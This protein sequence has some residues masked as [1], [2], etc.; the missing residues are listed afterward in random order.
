MLVRQGALAFELWTGKE[1]PLDVMREAT[2]AV[3]NRSEDGKP[4]KKTG[5][6]PTGKTSVALIGFM[7]AGKS[8]IG[9]ALAKKLGK[10]FVDVDKCIEKKAGKSIAHI[11]ADSGEPAF[12]ELERVITAEVARQAG[13]VIACGGG[14]VLNRSNTEALKKNAVLI[15]L[16]ASEEA[17]RKRVSPARG[18]RPLL[19]NGA[20]TESIEILMSARR[21]LYERAA[22]ITLDTSKLGIEAAACEIIERLGEYEGF[23]F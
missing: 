22:D 14:V 4:I 11:F 20:S 23:R 8:S 12:R 6:P 16:K 21:P 5:K 7:G 17:I 2:L 10:P 15:Y 13:Q 19:A 1:A 3:L 9:R 18:K